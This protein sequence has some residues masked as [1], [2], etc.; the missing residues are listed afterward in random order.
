MGLGVSGDDG[1]DAL[2]GAEGAAGPSDD[3]LV[4][5]GAPG[6]D[7][8]ESDEPEFDDGTSVGGGASPGGTAAVEKSPAMV[9]EGPESIGRLVS[10]CDV[11]ARRPPDAR[12]TAKATTTRVTT[13]I[14]GS[15]SRQ[16]VV[17]Q[18][19]SDDSHSA[20]APRPSAAIDLGWVEGQSGP[21]PGTG[22]EWPFGRVAWASDDDA[23]AATGTGSSV[24]RR[25]SPKAVCRAL[26][27]P[28]SCRAVAAPAAA[29]ASAS[30]PAGPPAEPVTRFRSSTG[31]GAHGSSPGDR[32]LWGEARKAPLGRDGWAAGEGGAAETA[33]AA[34]GGGDAAEGNRNRAPRARVRSASLAARARRRSGWRSAAPY[35]LRRGSEMA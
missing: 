21:E 16:R 10:T 19:P 30:W 29:S 25:S 35:S 12:T 3:G 18:S 1:F 5:T 2:E 8:G 31:S 9:V 22:A 7:L 17:H 20:G 32:P 34:S 26:P 24:I 33:A 13:T 15:S 11:S 4:V 14:P 23:T 6:A 27:K 28:D